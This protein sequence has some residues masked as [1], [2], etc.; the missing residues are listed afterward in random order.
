MGALSWFHD[1]SPNRRHGDWEF[2]EGFYYG[3]S[4]EAKEHIDALAGGTFFMLNAEKG[5]AIFE[6]LSSSERE[7]EEYGLKEDSCTAKIDPITRKFQGMAL[8]QPAMSE[9]HQA[10]Q[11]IQA[12]PS[13]G[14]KM[15]MSRI[16]SDAILHK[17]R[18]RL[19][20]PTLSIV[21]CILGP[22][23][24]HHALYEWG[25]SMSILPKLV[26]D[27]LDEDPLVPTPDQL[28]L[29][30]S[31]MMQP[32]GIA[33]DVLIEFHDSSTLV[34]FMVMD[35]DPHQQTS[36]IQGKPFLKSVRAT[37]DK[38]R[39]INNMKVDGVHE[40]FICH[41]KILVCCC[42]IWVHQFVG[43]RRVRCIEVLPEHMRSH[44][45]SWN[46]R[47]QNAMAPDKKPS[48]A[49]IFSTK[50]SRRIKN[51]TPTATSSL[52]AKCYGD[53]LAHRPKM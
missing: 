31:I 17:L 43:S 1:R 12:Q 42:Q 30:D 51:T 40:K 22:F 50:F 21:P 52:A 19:S 20:G 5:W 39:G 33:K 29:A 44:P 48:A 26:Y 47:P 49:K 41:P 25:A 11:E 3:L 8:T 46:R 32:Y 27:C 18:N 24:V 28:W 45:K 23:I 13:D 35:M 53:G 38:M 37:I 6:K 36:I 14:K 7:S 2:T 4:Q 34:D 16:S 9:A 10:E 15:P